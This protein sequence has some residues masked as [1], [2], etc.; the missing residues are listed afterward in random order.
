MCRH[1]NDFNLL[2]RHRCIEYKFSFMGGQQA[3]KFGCF[4]GRLW[5]DN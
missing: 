4:S 2:D 5:T 1:L 3:I